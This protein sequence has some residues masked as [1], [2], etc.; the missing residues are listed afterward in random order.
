MIGADQLMARFLTLDLVYAITGLL[1]LA[2]GLTTAG[3][4]HH[5]R[6]YVSG[7]FWI[8][9]GVI[10]LGGSLLPHWTTGLLAL[11]LVVLDG[12]GRVG[13]GGPAGGDSASKPSEAAASSISPHDPGNR[14]FWPVILIPAATFLLALLFRQAGLDANRGALVGLGLGSLLAM[15]IA[16]HLTRATLALLIREGR[17]LNEAMGPVNILPQLLASLG[18]ILAAA[19]IGQPIAAAIRHL[20]PGDNLFLMVLANCLG[21]ALLTILLGNSFAAFPVIA[22]GVMLPLLVIPFGVD[23]ALAAIITLTAGSSGTLMT[24]MAAN[25]NIVPAALLNLDDRYG[26]IRYQLSYALALWAFHVIW[27]WAVIRFF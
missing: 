4:R 12:S 17:R 3:D 13:Q 15:A 23:P 19:N 8:I 21:M 6:R 25:F 16:K 24:P 20:V 9:L 7:I 1:L 27:L 10:F 5:Q 18:A 11:V 14:I 22:S 26:V 2:F